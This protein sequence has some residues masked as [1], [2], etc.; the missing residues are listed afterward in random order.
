MIAIMVHIEAI[1]LAA[2]SFDVSIADRGPD[3]LFR[4]S[5]VDVRSESATLSIMS[6]LTNMAIVE[7]HRVLVLGS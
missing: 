5:S 7:M 4:L 2:G 6:L 3:E 1:T